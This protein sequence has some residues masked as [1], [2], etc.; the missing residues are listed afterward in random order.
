MQGQL[1]QSQIRDSPPQTVVL[2]LEILQPLDLSSF[3]LIKFSMP[4]VV[5]NLADPDLADRIK[6]AAILRHEN[7]YLT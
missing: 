7:I 2:N 4:T 1:I 5:S 6:N 3:Q